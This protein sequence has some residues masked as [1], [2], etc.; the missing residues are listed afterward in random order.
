MDIWELPDK[1]SNALLIPYV[2]TESVMTEVFL[3]KDID[4]LHRLLTEDR[5]GVR[6]NVTVLRGLEKLELGIIPDEAPSI[7]Q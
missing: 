7:D 5:V 2:L 3:L 6:S 1:A 4:D